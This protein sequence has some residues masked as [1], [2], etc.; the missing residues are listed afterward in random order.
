L[1]TAIREGAF[2]EDLFYRI[3][4]FSITLPPLRE[5]I[6]DIPFLAE[7]FLQRARAKVNK[8][9]ESISY[10]ALA[11]LKNYSWPG[12]LRELENII[13]RAVVLT[14]SSAI[15]PEHLPLHVQDIVSFNPTRG[16]KRLIVL[17]ETPCRVICLRL[18]ETY[19]EQ[20]SWR[21]FLVALFIA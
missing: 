11:M 12:N 21:R 14:L 9:V 5:R 18:A 13:E 19:L 4:T 7:Y 16:F 2:R 17:S 20:P 15:A 3:N 8:R 10:E 1:E 6:E